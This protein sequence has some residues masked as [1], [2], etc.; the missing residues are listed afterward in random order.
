MVGGP[1][2]G[3]SADPMILSVSEG[4][5]SSGWW[6]SLINKAAVSLVGYSIALGYGSDDFGLQVG[7]SWGICGWGQRSVFK[8]RLAHALGK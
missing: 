6:F 4:S 1:I 3:Y 2:A 8:R 7:K 5:P